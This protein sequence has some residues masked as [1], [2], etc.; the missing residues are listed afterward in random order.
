LAGL[1]LL[2]LRLTLAAILAAH[3]AHELFGVGAGPGI[4]PGGISNTA[5]LYAASGLHPEYVLA[6][7][8][9][10]IHLAGAFFLVIG[11]LT[12]FAS[13]VLIADVAIG[14]WKAH[15]P[16]GFFL[17]WS[18]ASGPGHG[19][20]Y[21]LLLIAALVCLL[22]TG[23]GDWSFDGRRANSAA[24]RAAGRARLRGTV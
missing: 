1:G 5:A 7:A 10:I 20:E 6:L 3:G 12:R 13:I 21:S 9:G 17:N 19:L 18:N 15:L 11:M 8:A 14:A 2:I 22:F 4:G 16:W 24:A 23:A